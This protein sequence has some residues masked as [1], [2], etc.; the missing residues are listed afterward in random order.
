MVFARLFMHD[1]GAIAPDGGA[2]NVMDGRY[3]PYV[4][5]EKVNATIPKETDPQSVTMEMAVEL[6]AARIEAT[7]KGK[8]K[9]PAA[10]KKA[11][12]KKA[13][14]KKAPAKKAPAKKAA[15]KAAPKAKPADDVIDE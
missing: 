7:G 5:W 14:A 3:G 2:V 13:P 15:K 8:K 12:A 6:I 11:P 1:I 9:K 4:K 10:K